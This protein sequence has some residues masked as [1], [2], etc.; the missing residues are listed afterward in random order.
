MEKRLKISRNLGLIGAIIP[1]VYLLVQISG[2]IGEALR[3]NNWQNIAWDDMIIFPIPA[4]V[5][6]IGALLV[7]KHPSIG[8]AL[9]LL[10]G[11]PTLLLVIF[12]TLSS[13]SLNKTEV[14]LYWWLTWV[15]PFSIAS[16]CVLASGLVAVSTLQRFSGNLRHN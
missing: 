1:L 12:S 5:A 15:A 10:V 14:D 6:L 9:L 11:A 8:A 3:N 13:S 16:A 2:T 4:L 7:L